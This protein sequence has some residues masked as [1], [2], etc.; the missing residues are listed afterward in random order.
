MSI[1]ESDLNELRGVV[2]TTEDNKTEEQQSGN[3]I[4]VKICKQHDPSL[5]WQVRVWLAQAHTRYCDQAQEQQSSD[6]PSRTQSPLLSLC[7]NN[8]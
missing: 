7:T 8:L 1:T 6:S 4:K 5:D 2:P 3:E